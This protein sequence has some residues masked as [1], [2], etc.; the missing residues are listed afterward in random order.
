MFVPEISLWDARKIWNL[1]QR[2][3]GIL[4]IYNCYLIC[5]TSFVALL[6][7]LPLDLFTVGAVHRH[8]LRWDT[9]TKDVNKSLLPNSQIIFLWNWKWKMYCFCYECTLSHLL[10][11]N[12]NYQ[13]RI[14]MS[15][16]SNHSSV[17][18][19]NWMK[20]RVCFG[21]HITCSLLFCCKLRRESWRQQ[22]AVPHF[23]RFYWYWWLHGP[24]HHI[25]I[26]MIVTIICQNTFR[27]C[28][29]NYC[30]DNDE[31]VAATTIPTLFC[32]GTKIAKWN[33]EIGEKKATIKR[34]F[35]QELY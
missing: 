1:I 3:S 24:H 8:H 14:W 29:I 26:Y 15:D 27:W 33:F 2:S 34:I 22:D 10:F 23:G 18:L 28:R 4:F 12:S 7:W 35:I 30:F 20:S 6:L 11:K 16:A 21:R 13:A 5:W 9:E 32:M 31:S 17:L 25:Y 19:I